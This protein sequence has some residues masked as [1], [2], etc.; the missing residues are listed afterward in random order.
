MLGPGSCRLIKKTCKLWYLNS[1]SSYDKTF[2]EY[3]VA[4]HSCANLAIRIL[5]L[6]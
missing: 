1:N 6:T 3:I 5:L 2:C 4:L